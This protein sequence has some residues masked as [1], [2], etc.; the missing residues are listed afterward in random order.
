MDDKSREDSQRRARL[1]D[2]MLLD[3]ATGDNSYNKGDRLII[4]Y[5]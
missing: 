2:H 1:G 5:A 4:L 3:Y